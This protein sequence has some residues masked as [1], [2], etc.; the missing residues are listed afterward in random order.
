MTTAADI[1]TQA[2]RE[3]N[4]IPIGDTTSAD[5][6][7]EGLF[8][9]QNVVSSVLGNEAGQPLRDQSLGFNNVGVP[10]YTVLETMQPYYTTANTR[11]VLNLNA[12][13]TI[14]LP[15][16]PEDGARFGVLDASNNLSTYN[17][18]IKGN[19]RLIDGNPTL[20][21]NTNG[22]AYE[23]FYRAD[24]GEWVKV[25]PITQTGTFPFP[26]QFNDLF[27]G[28]LALR[29]N[30]RAGAETQDETQRVIA[31]SLRQFKA[32]YYQTQEAPSE[33]SLLLTNPRHHLGWPLSDPNRQFNT[34]IIGYFFS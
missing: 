11:F 7:E 8:L 14:N 28:M 29:L 22:V 6:M 5:Q 13:V 25:L 23:W 30:P 20:V 21:L 33:L 34:G 10:D 1:I 4:L 17:A 24:L 19:G 3:T 12:A 27:I 16:T 18:T 31:R 9:L 26:P 32:K 15:P 2:Y